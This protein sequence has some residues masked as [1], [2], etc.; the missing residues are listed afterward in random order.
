MGVS[1]CGLVPP[2]HRHSGIKFVTPHQRHCGDAVK[3]AVTGLSSTSR[4]AKG[5]HADGHDQSGAGVNRKWCG[6][7]R[8]QPKLNST[9]LRCR[10]LT[11]QQQGRHLCWQSPKKLNLR[12]RKMH[13]RKIYQC[14]LKLQS[15]QAFN[16]KTKDFRGHKYN[17]NILAWRF[18][19]QSSG[20]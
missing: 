12:S 13:W 18:Y 17:H 3:S 19:G 6:S 10:W 7:I 16:E 14:R 4:H 5:V 20:L 11:E 1:V 9:Q 8:H 15:Y 2:L